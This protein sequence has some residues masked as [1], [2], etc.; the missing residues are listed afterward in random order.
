MELFQKTCI[1]CQGGVKPFS[2]EQAQAMK[3]QVHPDWDLK[4]D[5]THLTRNFRFKNFKDAM[6]LAIKIG[7]IA[8]AENHHP[9]LHISWGRLG[10]E[11]TTHKIKGLVES[12]FIFAAKVDNAFDEF[13]VH[14]G[15]KSTEKV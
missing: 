6:A 2:P 12:D 4:D 11:I 7:D 8:E 9:D 3:K 5:S 1:P 14:G 15:T 13:S 10:I